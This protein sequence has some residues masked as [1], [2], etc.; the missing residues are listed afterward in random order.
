[1]TLLPSTIHSATGA[2]PSLAPDPDGA[3]TLAERN[4]SHDTVACGAAAPNALRTARRAEHRLS[5]VRRRAGRDGPCSRR[6]VSI[7]T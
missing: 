7:S 2:D 1:M 4:G 6:A 5:G 3:E